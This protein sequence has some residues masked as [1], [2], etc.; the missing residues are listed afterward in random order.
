MVED[1]ITLL[2]EVPRWTERELIAIDAA[3]R[4]EIWRTSDRIAADGTATE[5]SFD[6]R[7]SSDLDARQAIRAVLGNLHPGAFLASTATRR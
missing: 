5:I 6:V 1:R 2:V 3:E 4:V 7:A